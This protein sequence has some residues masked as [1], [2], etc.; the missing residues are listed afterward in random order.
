MLRD[1]LT[2]IG[3]NVYWCWIAG[4]CNANGSNGQ[5]GCGLSMNANCS[6]LTVDVFEFYS[7]A[8]RIDPGVACVHAIG[9][10]I[11]EESRREAHRDP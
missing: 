1:K 10:K 5:S 7:R 2:K 6:A 3:A 11:T 8:A 4:S 9:D